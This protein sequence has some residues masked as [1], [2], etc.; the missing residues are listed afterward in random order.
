MHPKIMIFGNVV[1]RMGEKP[2]SCFAAK[3][4]LTLKMREMVGTDFQFLLD[5]GTNPVW[6]IWDAEKRQHEPFDF[7][8]LET[9]WKNFGP[10][11]KELLDGIPVIKI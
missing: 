11:W 9:L 8:G 1:F 4:A 3:K 5:N 6:F 7:A 10:D 2:E